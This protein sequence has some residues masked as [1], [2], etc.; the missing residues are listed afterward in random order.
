MSVYA[1]HTKRSQAGE[2]A[3]GRQK[4]Q[5]AWES[6][7]VRQESFRVSLRAH[8]KPLLSAVR[9]HALIHCHWVDSFA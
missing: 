4:S 3:R 2:K 5:R 8:S 9:E 7:F 6:Y 1:A